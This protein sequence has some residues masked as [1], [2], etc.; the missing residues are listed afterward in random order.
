MEP[1]SE[2]IEVLF[3]DLMVSYFHTAPGEPRTYL[4]ESFDRAIHG[5]LVAEPPTPPE[6][7]EHGVKVTFGGGGE[8]AEIGNWG[9]RGSL[10]VTHITTDAPQVRPYPGSPDPL[11]EMAE[12]DPET[13]D[14]AR[15]L[16]AAIARLY[17]EF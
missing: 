16:A 8:P 10:Q 1:F 7:P 11:A 12:E 6:N 15:L 9:L 17:T 2:M 13:A 14:L 3:L 5:P 4:V